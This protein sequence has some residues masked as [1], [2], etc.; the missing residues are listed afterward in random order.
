MNRARISISVFLCFL[1]MMFQMVTGC[2]SGGGG[3][4]VPVVAV[5]P[6]YTISGTVGGAIAAGVTINLT[7]AATATTVTG[8]GGTY[9]FT[10]L[11]NGNYT[12]RPS[13]TGHYFLPVGTAVV[14]TGANRPGIDFT[15]GTY[16]DPLY[17]ISGTVHGDALEHVAGVT[18]TLSGD[19]TGTTTTNAS[20][21]YSFTGL[22]GAGCDYIVTPT[23][24]GYAFTPDHQ[25]AHVT[26]AD[27]TTGLDFDAVSATVTWSQAD[28]EGTWRMNVLERGYHEDRSPKNKWM[29]GMMTIDVN[30][31]ATCL[32]Y[33][34]S[35][36]DPQGCPSSFNLTVV[37]DNTT[38]VITQSGTHAVDVGGHMTMTANKNFAAGT[39]TNGNAADPGQSS[40]QLMII[41][42]VV[43]GTS[44]TAA[45]QEKSFVYHELSVGSNNEWRYGAGTTGTAGAINI[46]S[47]TGPDGPGTSGD[48]GCTFSVNA[49]SGVVTM[50]GA[51]CGMTTFQGFLSDDRK[52]MVGTWTDSWTTPS[53]GTDYRLMI[54]Q[55]TGQTYNA[56]FLPDSVSASHSLGADSLGAGWIHSNI[57]VYGSGSITFEGWVTSFGGSAPVDAHTGNINSSGTVTITEDLSF[58]GQMSHDGKFIVATQTPEDG[59]FGLSVITNPGYSK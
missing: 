13:I 21:N 12:V 34:D 45:L 29:R 26:T 8:A 46:S 32:S 43:T 50:T 10:G 6:T 52:T 42:R 25:D 59:L 17:T 24:T 20:G 51:T 35:T 15:A 38:G 9:S 28:L 55:I 58:H 7:G 44:Y 5:A 4:A 16:V 47:E 27:I 48:T 23:M 1:M 41:Q 40:H 14:V 49:A 56:G 57:I 39:G 53:P 18:I 36:T 30:G 19:A 22:R 54:A 37:I 31:V 11:A 2:S 33:S 3:D